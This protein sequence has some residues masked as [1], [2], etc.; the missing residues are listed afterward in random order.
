MARII[1]HRGA[2]DLAPE[3]TLASIRK[4]LEH[5]VDEIEIDL[6][7]TRDGKVVLAHDASVRT[8]SGA[9]FAIA[10]HTLEELRSR[11][12][13][14]ATFEEAVRDI[15]RQVPMY[16]E[17][18]PKVPL[19]PIIKQVKK[20]LK[21]G[22]LPTD[23]YLASFSQRTLLKLHTALPEIEK[24][25]IERWSTTRA[26]LRARQLHARRLAMNYKYVW[27]G[28]IALLHKLGFELYPYNLDD[29][30]K[31]KRWVRWGIAGTITN[32]PN[33]YND[34]ERPDKQ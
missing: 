7:V 4:A 3:N 2:K 20:F 32:V 31:Y 22:W 30:V 15:N 14:L 23:F 16:V 13:N 17:V 9:K 8:P 19:E 29:P 21:E 1:G 33:K 27:L 10:T 5:H 28:N 34:S 11:K 24:I 6:R 26:A 12:P 18:K 25:V